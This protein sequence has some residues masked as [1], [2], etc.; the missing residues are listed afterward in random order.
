M[1]QFQYDFGNMTTGAF[2]SVDWSILWDQGA[3][4]DAF[5]VRELAQSM[6][7]K[8][9]RKEADPNTTWN[10][11]VVQN[12]FHATQRVLAKVRVIE[13]NA[14]ILLRAV[15][16]NASSA[17][18]VAVRL[19][20]D[21]AGQRLQ[22][23]HRVSGTETV[24]ATAD[25]DV[26]LSGWCWVAAE[27]VGETISAK[28]WADGSPMPQNWQVTASTT[29]T[30][31]SRAGVFRRFSRFDV[32]YFALGTD[33]DAAPTPTD[34]SHSPSLAPTAPGPFT[35]PTTAGQSVVWGQTVSVGP[36]VDTNGGAVQYRFQLR[37]GNGA[38][39]TI[40][41]WAS[42]PSFELFGAAHPHGADYEMRAEARPA[43]TPDA[44]SNYTLSLPFTIEA[45]TDAL[46]PPGGFT[47]PTAGATV[48]GSVA[49]VWGAAPYAAHYEVQWWNGEEWDALPNTT[50]TA[51]NK[52]VTGIPWLVARFRVRAVI[53]TYES[54]WVDS[55][56]FVVWNGQAAAVSGA[57]VGFRSGNSVML[58]V[59]DT[60]GLRRLKAV[61][62]AP[63]AAGTPLVQVT[64][65]EGEGRTAVWVT[66]LGPNTR[67]LATV[68][69]E[70]MDGTFGAVTEP[71]LFRTRNMVASEPAFSSLLTVRD[72]AGNKDGVHGVGN[73]N[74]IGLPPIIEAT[75]RI[76]FGVPLNGLYGVRYPTRGVR[77]QRSNPASQGI[78]GS[79]VVPQWLGSRQ[80]V[81][82]MRDSSMFDTWANRGGCTV[83]FAFIPQ[84]QMDMEIMGMGSTYVRA[85]AQGNVMVQ[86]MMTWT[87]AGWRSTHAMDDLGIPLAKYRLNELN[88]VVLSWRSPRITGF[89]TPD[90]CGADIPI[91]TDGFSVGVEL[92]A[93][94]NSASQHR[95]DQY[96][97]FGE[98]GAKLALRRTLSQ[99]SQVRCG[100]TVTWP[101]E[102][103]DLSA[104]V[105]WFDFGRGGPI[106]YEAG[107]IP[108]F[109]RAFRGI[110][111]E[112]AIFPRFMEPAE[113][114][115]IAA[116]I[117]SGDS[118]RQGILA[119]Q[120]RVYLPFDEYPG[121]HQPVVTVRR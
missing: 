106:A 60:A 8:I 66:G 91:A 41:D 16:S 49:A 48:S 72:A 57:R 13:N 32:D 12:G 3:S 95:F 81:R 114:R 87:L 28:V 50:A 118:P 35:W 36:S 98:A 53:G 7:G 104:G 97:H 17:T 37:Y 77:F 52:D 54:A 29:V 121:P 62:Y 112:A 99:A 116:Q 78:V 43:L 4:F 65:E 34:G 68:Q 101:I 33:L 44:V 79:Q 19:R 23:W 30:S 21:V 51:A 38:W 47:A 20:A 94:L 111:V 100:S 22:I 119:A 107:D 83:L 58:A 89:D 2:P 117:L 110:G 82:V 26:N 90:A 115:G 96:P 108:G 59:D 70:Y 14:S 42:S 55:P 71:V 109:G 10:E 31:Q 56:L 39:A 93:T 105:Q 76:E 88:V 85:D 102:F 64:G 74:N 61:L 63:E 120:P 5:R 75:A 27:A 6:G 84:E 18:F 113:Q 25:P 80:H 103:E 86:P 92:A 9:L 45:P 73:Y 46:A 15:Y 11:A 40:R 24:L 69:P 67:Y 1:A